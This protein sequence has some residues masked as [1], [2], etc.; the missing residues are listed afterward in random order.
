MKLNIVHSGQGAA[1]AF[2]D[3]AV[4]GTLFSKI[5]DASQLP[6]ILSIYERLR[7]PRTTL[8]RSRSRAMQE[9]YQFSDGPLQQERDRQLRNHAPFDGF[10]NFLADPSLQSLLF[11]YNAIKEAEKAWETYLKGEW[12]STRGKWNIG[13]QTD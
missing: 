1:T 11:G 7:K 3:A 5:Q 9:V 2:E 12:P 13:S 10:P 6:D 4:L 8:L